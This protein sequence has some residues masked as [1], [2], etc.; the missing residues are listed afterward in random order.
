MSFATNS[1]TLAMLWLAVLSSP[2]LG[3]EGKSSDGSFPNFDYEVICYAKNIFV[4]QGGSEGLASIADCKNA[5][6][7]ARDYMR[8][9]WPKLLQTGRAACVDEARRYARGSYQKLRECVA[10]GALESLKDGL[11]V[12]APAKP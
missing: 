10:F 9:V 7:Y 4:Q 1:A 12:R 3:E 11:L 6:E 8:E 5:E 2:S